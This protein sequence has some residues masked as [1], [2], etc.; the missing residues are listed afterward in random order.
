MVK[1]FIGHTKKLKNNTIETQSLRDHLLNT[2]K[3]AEKYASDLSLEHVA[4]LAG[5]L[6]DLG[7]YQSKFQEYI[8]EST[9]K[10]DQSKKGSIDHSSFGAIFLRDFISENFSEK[11][12]YYDFVNCNIKLD[13]SCSLIDVV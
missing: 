9:R 4:G 12:N 7:K 10:G 3:Y 2:Q 6:H 8:I 1:N 5:I 11:E 13:T